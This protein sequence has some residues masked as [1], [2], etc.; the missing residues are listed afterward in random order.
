MTS[1]SEQGADTPRLV[2]ASASATRHGILARAGLSVGCDVA[3]ID[4]DEVKAALRAAGAAAEAVAEKLAEMKALRVSMRQPGAIVLGADQM[5]DCEGRW[6]DKPT[7][8]AQARA[9][10]LAL[11]GRTHRL[12]SAVVAMRDGARLWHHREAA[13]LTMRP[14]SEAFVD[15][16]LDAVGEAALSSVG[17]YQIEGPGAQLFARVEGDW[18]TI[19]GL[20]LLPLLAFLRE[21]GV[22]AA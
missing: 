14:L 9:Q 21:Q 1:M 15:R 18:F 4:E 11:A 13:R 8:R 10:L 22:V 12:I 2:L 20:P 16:Y 17:A 5:L 19:L 3:A 6:L 7:D